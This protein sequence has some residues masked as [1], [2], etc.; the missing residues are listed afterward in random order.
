MKKINK[1]FIPVLISITI[2]GCTQ[3]T[4]KE[5]YIGQ[6]GAKALAIESSGVSE[7]NVVF[8][9]AELSTKNGLNYYEIDFTS[10]G[11]RYEYDVDAITGVIIDSRT[12]K[13]SSAENQNSSSVSNSNGSEIITENQAQE[14][15]LN[16]AGLKS[17]EVKIIKTK[18]DWDDGI[19][20][21]EV[22]FYSSNNK[23]YDYEINAVTGEIISYD[24]DAE[25]S[26]Q[27]QT[28]NSE[29]SADEAKNIALSQVPGAS[30]DNIYDFEVDY[31]DG[32]L[33]YEGK[34]I[35]SETE[36]EFSIDG[37]SG[38]I[39]SWEAESIYD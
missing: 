9:K 10:E 37:Y 17:D 39:R 12:E 36:Y 26:F 16:H 33:E 28:N 2:C 27:A 8:E 31:D 3:Q 20:K 35:Y 6:E 34:I 13:I 1:L 7:Q 4:S 32:R 25:Y 5:E 11:V 22:E 15:A 18:L 30:A 38:A 19:Q 23:E 21:Y 29:I 24:Y 14:T